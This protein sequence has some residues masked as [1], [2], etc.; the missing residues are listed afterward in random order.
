V[1]EATIDRV[2]IASPDRL[3]RNAVH[4]MVLLEECA[5]AGCGVACLDQPLGHDPQAHLLLHIRGAVAA[6]ART[7][8]A[9]RMRRG[10]QRKLQAGVLLPWTIP[11]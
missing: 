6:Y 4:Q 2:V 8:T 1:K 7:L 3:A 11:P 5:Q 9:E 10:R